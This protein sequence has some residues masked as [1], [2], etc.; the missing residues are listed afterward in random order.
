MTAASATPPARYTAAPRPGWALRARLAA[1]MALEALSALRGNTPAAPLGEPPPA[2]ARPAWWVYVSTIGELNAIAPLLDALV[3]RLHP[4]PLVLVTDHPHYRASYLARYPQAEVFVT[5]GHRRDARQLAQRRPPRLMVVAEI[6]LLPSDAPCRCSAA[7]LLAARRSGAPLVA[8]N[9]W[10][11]GYAPSCRMD[12]I[13]RRW[14]AGPLLRQFDALCVQTA[15]VAQQ[16]QAAG[17]APQRLHVTGNLKFDALRQPVAWQPRQARSP[18]LVG[19]LASAGRP[20]VVAGSMTR[21][22]EQATVVEAY[23]ALRRQH[24]QALLVLALRHPEVP[25]NLTE[26]DSQLAAHDLPAVR[27]TVHGDRPLPDT[28]A[29]LVLDT[30]GELRD[31]Y[32]LAAVAHVGVDHNVLEPLTHGKP[33]STLPGWEATYPSFP[34]YTALA[35]AGALLLAQ[36]AAELQAHWQQALQDHAAGRTAASVQRAR[37]ALAGQDTSVQRHLEALAPCLDRA[38]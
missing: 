31:F 7:L 10:L 38:V 26:V 21:S 36:G 19:A 17:A 33:T 37:Q 24:P 34:V 11:Y 4:L 22:D 32:A 8:V 30:I 12:A 3:Q 15:A 18:A 2:P 20:L 1:F 5:L 29:C 28:V 16:L 13:E 23:A 6:P 9:G 25:A 35:D 27:R 14:F